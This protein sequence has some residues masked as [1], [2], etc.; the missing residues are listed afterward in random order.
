MYIVIYAY[1]T[2]I[3]DSIFV[4]FPSFFVVYVTISILFSYIINRVLKKIS[5]PYL[6]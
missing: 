2:K 6:I 1:I 3:S 4:I 5:T